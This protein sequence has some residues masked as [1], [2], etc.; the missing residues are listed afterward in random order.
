MNNIK[1]V[2]SLIRTLGNAWEF[3]KSLWSWEN[4]A[5]STAAFIIFLIVCLFGELWMFFVIGAF[6]FLNQY[7]VVYIRGKHDWQI[8]QRRALSIHSSFEESNEDLSDLSD[9]TDL[10]DE[11]ESKQQ[12]TRKSL[13]EKFRQIQ[14]VLIIVQNV[15][16]FLADLGERVKNLFDWS[17]PFLCWMAVTILL[18]ASILFYF[19]PL[20][21]VILV[22]GKSGAACVWTVLH[23]LYV[24]G[25]DNT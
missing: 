13:R 3:I 17:V 23:C 20:R 14:E 24:S 4:K 25:R 9:F 11:V 10:E 15:L 18:L 2:M 6:V 5:K 7:L 21:Y 19:V 1:R 16:G 12:D 22:W 8:N